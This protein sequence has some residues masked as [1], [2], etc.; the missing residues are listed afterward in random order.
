M[1]I[2]WD[3]RLFDSKAYGSDRIDA[4]AIP[5][6]IINMSI[7]GVGL[8]S[9]FFV[10]GSAFTTEPTLCISLIISLHIKYPGATGM[11]IM[12]EAANVALSAFRYM[13]GSGKEL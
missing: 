9:F 2:L 7:G 5:T 12:P 8:I 11:G 10:K 1:P 13:E 3:G 4:Q 6:P